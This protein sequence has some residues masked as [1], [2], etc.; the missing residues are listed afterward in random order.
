MRDAFAKRE[1]H[2]GILDRA[3]KDCR[4]KLPGILR[5][6]LLQ[7]MDQILKPRAVMIL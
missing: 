4:H 1:H 2:M 3:R 6:V 7:R 5:A